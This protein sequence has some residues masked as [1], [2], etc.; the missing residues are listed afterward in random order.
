[1]S[2]AHTDGCN[3]MA[4]HTTRQHVVATCLQCH[5]GVGF[6]CI[7]AVYRLQAVIN[8]LDYVWLG[9]IPNSE[10]FLQDKER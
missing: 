3:Y 6:L 8:I 4:M 2:H 10:D 1:M 7:S 9:W 5:D